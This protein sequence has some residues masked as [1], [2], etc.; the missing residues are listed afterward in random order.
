MSCIETMKHEVDSDYFPN[1]LLMLQSVGH[2][3]TKTKICKLI[4]KLFFQPY[5]NVIVD[6]KS[7]IE[8]RKGCL[9]KMIVVFFHVSVPY[10]WS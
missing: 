3:K 8:N 10:N 6:N 7:D 2:F 4:W 5:S 9:V 1:A